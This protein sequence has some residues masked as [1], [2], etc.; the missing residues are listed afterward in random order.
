M[1]AALGLVLAAVPF[2]AST[3]ASGAGF[4]P[5]RSAGVSSGGYPLWF[6]DANG[7]RAELCL[8]PADTNCLAPL[9][10]P[11]YDQNLPLSFPTNYPDELF[12]SA[13]DSQ[14]VTAVDAACPS[15]GGTID[16][17]LA[18][19]AAFFNGEPAVGDQAVFGRIRLNADPGSGLCGS[20]W[21]TFN[22]PYG[23]LTVQTEPDGAILG[24][25]AS[26]ATIDIGCFPTPTVPCAF[27]ETLTAP[28]LQIGFLQQVAAAPQGYLGDGS[29]G[30]VTGGLGGYNQFEI[31]KWPA[32]STPA[33]AGYE[34]PC[35]GDCTTVAST[36]NFAVL[37]KLA[38]AISAST[39]SFDFGGQVTGTTG[40]SPQITLTNVGGGAL[41]LDAAAI[42]DLVVSGAGFALGATTCSVGT[43]V[44]PLDP[45][46][47][48]RD[49]N[50]WVTVTFNP[51]VTGTA[52][53]TLEIYSDGN[54]VP[55]VVQLVG[56]GINAGD[57]PTADL[58]AGD[59]GF[60]EVRLRTVSAT[61]SFTVSNNGN[62]PLQLL[63]SVVGVNAADFQIVGNSCPSGWVPALETCTIDVRFVP[64]INGIEVASVSLQTNIGLLAVA[65]EGSG[66]GGFAAVST[67]TDPINTFPDW[68]QDE[69]GT[70]VGQCVQPTNPMCVTAPITG[71]LSFPDNYPDEW[72]YYVANSAP[73]DVSDPECEAEPGSIM[74]EAAAEAA[75][76]GEIAPNEGITFGR[77]RIVAHGGL[78]ADTT[79]LLT[80]PYGQTV[81]TTNDLGD[82][83]P[84]MGTTDIGC[85]VLPCNYE[86]A[87]SSP[88]LESFLEQTTRPGGWLGDPLQPSTVTG[89]PFIDPTTGQ[90]ANHFYVQRY[91]AGG[92]A[93]P[94]I[95]YTDQFT[96]SGRL[97]GP[98]VATPGS[99]TFADAEAGVP[100]D[101]STATVTFSNSGIAPI[102]LDAADAVTVEGNRATEFTVTDTTCIEN[103]ELA[104]GGECSVTL[105]F[106][107]M[108]TG[109]RDAAVVLHHSGKNSPT[110]VPLNG[111]GLAPA[112][113][114]AFSA[115][116]DT[117]QFIDLHVLDAINPVG[118]E[119]Q[120][121][122]ISNVGGQAS[123]EVL[124]ASVPVD[125]DYVI[126]DNACVGVLVAPGNTCTI[127]VRFT[128]NA[129]GNRDAA[130]TVTG[131][132]F[133]GDPEA[134]GPL[135][136]VVV[137]LKGN[138][139]LTEPALSAGSTNGFFNW[140]QDRNGVRLE[141]CLVTDG[142]CVLL[143]DATFNPGQP[144][145]FPNNYPSESFYSFVDSEL[146]SFGPQDCGIAGP[147]A[148]GTA[149]LRIV[150]EAAFT[151]PQPQAGTQNL[152]N[153]I[154]LTADG[155]CANTTY[156]VMTPY[157]PRTVITDGE[158][159]VLPRTGTFDN[160]NITGTEPVSRSFLQW[161]P[162]VG[163]KAPAGYLGSP[164][165]FHKVVGSQYIPEGAT[166]PANYFAIL[167][168][169]GEVVRTELFAVA[170]R[171]AGPV[172]TSLTSK[173]FG[174]VEGGGQSASQTIVITNIGSAPV[175]SLVVSKSGID[176]GQ[177]TIVSEN[178]STTASLVRDDHCEIVVR[179]DPA[180][181]AVQTVR[182][183][184][185]TVTHSGLRSP[186]NIALTG[187]ANP[188]ET[189]ALT[190]TPT[191]FAFT[192]LNVGSTASTIITVRN[193]GT[194][195][196]TL[197]A[198]A[199]V[200]P[201][202]SISANTCPVTP[203]TLGAGVSCQVTARFNPASRG[204]KSASFQV[205]AHDA[206]TTDGHTA[207]IFNPVTVNLTG[208][209]TQ[210]T[211]TVS[212][213][214]TVN[215]SGQAGRAQTAKVTITNTGNGNF[216]LSSPVIG[217][218]AIQFVAVSANNPVPRFGATHNCTNII[219]G[220][221]C[222]VTVSFT[223]GTLGI[224][225]TWSVDMK[226]FGNA[227]NLGGSL[228]P[229]TLRVNGTR[230]K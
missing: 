106:A 49:E 135:A 33:D 53:G 80:H 198:M 137:S 189:P 127:S 2:M 46:A 123:L 180:V 19:E 150:T 146:V 24:G 141:Q 5:A 192:A 151:S 23:P 89:A 175:G 169:A 58:D 13:V 119:S 208:I 60:F 193:P 100:D 98:V 162:N 191:S 18:L 133:T 155:L 79:Y 203:N 6:Q 138:G 70:R 228:T 218:A 174:V 102:T 145:S 163:A 12:Y 132:T 152:F 126:T 188:P 222:T 161:D 120:Q 52:N 4:V 110:E 168:G 55:E 96:V 205:K 226:L 15:T 195:A 8:D 211:V 143:G 131:Q 44:A 199:L 159:A 147:S 153:R 181:V 148:G 71:A 59:L 16:V 124:G 95:A 37:T 26:A 229:Y 130:L 17:H 173:D 187:R 3:P 166:E 224:G 54:P 35:V 176:A 14:P 92:P 212:P 56:T 31:Q 184:T 129:A 219:P 21:Y 57:A 117:V 177:F 134:P 156:T 108:G 103:A 172:V 30:P 179:F 111:I 217:Q 48:A 167:G 43:V 144:V 25:A 105:T 32:D 69:N 1:L 39:E 66:Y 61:K 214:A 20:T 140:I 27:N 201:D 186:I 11:G 10:G 85:T 116:R 194:G 45:T 210:P 149:L 76:L 62:A 202:F 9:S 206:V 22:T 40:T 72:F 104:P 164:N 157:G 97:V 121:V 118:S 63:P 50:C 142:N 204:A 86:E 200:N 83:K 68:Y 77:L 139:V 128:P 88:V 82:I 51:G 41:G 81:I 185:L 221:S 113:S 94:V 158:G 112:G 78:C 7:V 197:D 29:F 136:D 220:K 36:A 190:V 215:I 87:L 171:L 67:T 75:F 196:L 154:R 227:S 182:N 74:V 90:P 34:A 42:D 28:V 122:V 47:L 65:L 213:A 230:N 170:G 38:G 165:V 107:P 125:A 216:S 223:A 183:A 109:D 209:A 160:T 73:L 93:A 64:S 99:L 84:N 207:V 115:V 91:T 114:A 101:V 178:C 225:T